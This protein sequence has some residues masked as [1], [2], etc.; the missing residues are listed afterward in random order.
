MK[1]YNEYVYRNVFPKG[2][3]GWWHD[4][5]EPDVTNSLTKEAHQLRQK[6]LIIII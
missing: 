6:N 5:T 2:F 3:D 1:L 4:S